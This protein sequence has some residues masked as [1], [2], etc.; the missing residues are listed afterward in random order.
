[1]SPLVIAGA[2]ADTICTLSAARMSGLA[3][4]EGGLPQN[5]PT[6]TTLSTSSSL[7]V[8][9][10]LAVALVSSSSTWRRSL[11]PPRMP[12]ASLTLATARSAAFF[13]SG[14]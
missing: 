14:P 12:P 8:A 11:R 10:T 1:M 3:A 6:M 4:S 2:E 7:R 13:M 9:A 5:P